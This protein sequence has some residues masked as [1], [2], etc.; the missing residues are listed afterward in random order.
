MNLR[1]RQV[2]AVLIIDCAGVGN[3]MAVMP[4]KKEVETA[5]AAGQTHLAIHLGGVP[6]VDQVFCRGLSSAV[7]A[8]ERAGGRLCIIGLTPGNQPSVVKYGAGLPVAEDEAD[9]L[10]LLF[11]GQQVISGDT[12]VV[13]LGDDP[14][15]GA[16]LQGLSHYKHRVTFHRVT[17]PTAA[18]AEVRRLA[19]RAVFVHP[20]LGLPG[21]RHVRQRL[22]T[23][24]DAPVLIALGTPREHAALQVMGRQEGYD[25]ILEIPFSSI[26]VILKGIDHGGFRQLLSKKL[27]LLLEGWY[28]ERRQQRAAGGPG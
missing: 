20:G 19:P 8:A 21:I 5:I 23:G 2:G 10:R 26:E 22:S 6:H 9:A 15:L 16:A 18:L 12:Q 1:Q 13:F 24:K 3:G 4:L 25:D 17:R 27:D 11:P 28:H 7:T 14:F